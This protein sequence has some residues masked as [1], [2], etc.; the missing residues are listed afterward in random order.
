MLE[1]IQS[2]H[3]FYGEVRGVMVA[4]KH[5]AWYLDTLASLQLVDPA[6]TVAMRREFNPL[7]GSDAQLDRISL[8]F[9]S[10]PDDRSIAA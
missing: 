10:T 7:D 3:A 4:R 5:V 8:W 2:L 6:E 9:P 1:H